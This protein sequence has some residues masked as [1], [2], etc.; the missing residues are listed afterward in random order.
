MK[1]KKVTAAQMQS[2]DRRASL[3]FAIP[4]LLLMENA[5]RG[6]AELCTEVLSRAKTGP[7]KRALVLC[8]KGNNGGDGFAAARHLSNRGF[9]VE[10]FLLA[11]PAQLKNDALLNY[12]IASSM[13]IPI[14]TI[15][16][17]SDIAAL[18][19][20]LVKSHLSLDALFG[21]GFKG[22]ISGI[23][24]E[25][26]DALN[27]SGKPVV[28]ADIPSGLDAD[29]GSVHGVAIQAKWTGTLGLPKKGL[30]EGEG[31]RHAGEI[32][33][34]DIGLPRELLVGGINS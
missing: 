8:G 34:I 27:S 25:A 31:P 23:Y 19:S 5:G 28:A 21:V 12:Q 3:E 1:Y 17:E 14:E 32:R 11:A 4:S 13:K 9:A 33:V 24:E 26:I 15:E 30:Y 29:D 2:L 16:E 6:L 18:R 10:I 22:E 20:A 7:K